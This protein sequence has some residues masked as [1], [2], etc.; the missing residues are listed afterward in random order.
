VRGAVVLDERSPAPGPVDDLR[1][2]APAAPVDVPPAAARRTAPADPHEPGPLPE[3]G[4]DLDD[5]EDEDPPGPEEER[6]QLTRVAEQVVGDIAAELEGHPEA[7]AVLNTAV[8]ALEEWGSDEEPHLPE[9]ERFDDIDFPDDPDEAHFRVIVDRSEA[10]DILL[11]E[12]RQIGEG[13]RFQPKDLYDALKR[14]ALKS[15]SWVR[16]SMPLLR[17]WGCIAEAERFGEYEIIHTRR[18]DLTDYTES[19]DGAL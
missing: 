4:F 1:A 17:K 19:P 6:E 13:E 15:D 5:D 10:I 7:R 9:G 11:D 8:D 16:K 18:G 2:A 12:L 3:T 14:R